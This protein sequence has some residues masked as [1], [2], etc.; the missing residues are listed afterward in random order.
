[1]KNFKKLMAITT[2]VFTLTTMST[3][4]FATS[5]D[6][7]T[8]TTTTANKHELVRSRSVDSDTEMTSKHR[9]RTE[10]TTERSENDGKSNPHHKSNGKSKRHG[11]APKE[12]L[13][14]E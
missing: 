6:V 8:D 4:V 9:Q 12:Q 13:V 1:M 11:K 14:T 5:G 7:I 3:T 2:A 10:F